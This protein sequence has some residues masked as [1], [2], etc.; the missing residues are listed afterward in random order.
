MFL[1][2]I[3]ISIICFK[4]SEKYLTTSKKVKKKYH[5]FLI[6]LKIQISIFYFTFN[7]I[8]EKRLLLCEMIFFQKESK[9]KQGEKVKDLRVTIV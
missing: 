1:C 6:R 5:K 2:K 8:L 7:G 9:M 3:L 4:F